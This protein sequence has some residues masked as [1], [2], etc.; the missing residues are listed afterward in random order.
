MDI[1]QLIL[2]DH[3]EQRR[4][5]AVLEQVDGTDTGT[6]G[7]VWSRLAAFLELHA[8]AEEEIFYPA[9]LDAGLR[10]GHAK[11]AE[12][13]TLDAIGSF[14]GNVGR[15]LSGPATPPAPGSEIGGPIPT[16]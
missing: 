10:S 14:F 4:L 9:L 1:T 12:D 3:Y 6:L 15:A 16:D 13:E 5:F 8:V 2:D 11:S 7:Q